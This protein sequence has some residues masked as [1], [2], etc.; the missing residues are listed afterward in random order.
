MPR[1]VN[2]DATIC[3][4]MCGARPVLK[5]GLR[6]VNDSLEAGEPQHKVHA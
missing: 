4:Y 3:V 1:H 2:V 5:Q 6:V